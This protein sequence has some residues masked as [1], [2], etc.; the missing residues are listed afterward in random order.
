MKKNL[1]LIGILFSLLGCEDYSHDYGFDRYY[2]EI[3]TV[4]EKKVFL[5]DNGQTLLSTT[6]LRNPAKDGERV[7]LHYTLLPEQTT[8]YDHTVR[9]NGAGSVANAD[10][11]A[12]APD[13]VRLM[14]NEVVR[15]ESLWI[16]SHFLNMQFYIDYHSKAH[17]IGLVADRLSLDADPVEIYFKHDPNDD[18]K[19]F[20]SHLYASFNL[21]DVLGTPQRN[22]NI[23]IHINTSNYG[24]KT[25]DLVY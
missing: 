2:E 15:L 1:V 3:V 12:V 13:S 20:P 9:I 23:R 17:S 21:K 25:Y 16:G 6:E 22:K 19:G 4:L 14:K 7:L 10:L 18:P 11:E 5:L 24:E 8:G